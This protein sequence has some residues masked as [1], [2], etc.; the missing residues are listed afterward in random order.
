M[1]LTLPVITNKQ[2]FYTFTY[3]EIPASEIDDIRVL[4]TWVGGRLV[5]EAGAGE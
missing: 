2:Y 4:Q 3:F 1:I 5:Y